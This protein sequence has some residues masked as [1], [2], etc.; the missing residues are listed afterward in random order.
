MKEFMMP[1][2]SLHKGR[3]LYISEK[4]GFFGGVE[5][6]IFDTAQVLRKNGFSVSGLF[7][8]PARD[9]EIFCSTFEDTFCPEDLDNIPDDNFDMAF[10]HKLNDFR[11]I[12]RI[13]NKF[14]TAVF[15]HDHDY[16]CLRRHKYFPFCRKNCSLPQSRVY[17]PICSCFVERKPNGTIGLIDFSS[18]FLISRQIRKCDRF[19]V[20]SDFMRNN[21]LMNKFPKN[22][23]SKLYPVHPVLDEPPSKPDGPPIILFCGQLIKGKGVDLLIRALRDVKS[24]YQALIVGSGSAENELKALVKKYSLEN[25]VEFKG[26]CS[27]PRI[28]LKK[29]AIAVTPARW[30]E[31]FGLTGIE[32]MSAGIPVVG[33]NVGGI[34]EWLKNGVNGIVVKAGDV[35]A[36][37]GAIDKLLKNPE[38]AA[39]YGKAGQ[40][41][42]AARYNEQVFID[43]LSAILAKLATEKTDHV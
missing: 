10:I 18:K 12:S 28:I 15:V 6:Y 8:E 30:Q 1:D 9:P 22:A 43:G 41:Q 39:V 32:A 35:K 11:L 24:D 19:I 14:P 40:Q 20:M 3:I 7:L 37:A 13:R 34:T 29:A 42:I 4:C 5:R 26:W 21:L 17:C 38:M 23:I 16:Y 2:K 36:F 31:P 25:R 27:D 33:F